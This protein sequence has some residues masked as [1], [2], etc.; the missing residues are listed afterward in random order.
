MVTLIVLSGLAMAD[1]IELDNGAHIDGTLASWASDGECRV[2]LEDGELAGT[3][4]LMPCDRIVRFDRDEG[5][6]AASSEEH[7]PS[8]TIL[9][10]PD[11]EPREVEVAASPLP[12]QPL[13][14]PAEAPEEAPVRAMSPDQAVEDLEADDTKGEQVAANEAPEPT[15]T[16]ARSEAPPSNRTLGTFK[17]NL[18]KI[19]SAD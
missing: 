4:L 17:V 1:T 3:M 5:A 19:I 9:L 15:D 11:E 13:A 7:V 6:A 12:E 2:A 16:E 18:P 14:M 8:G 10:V